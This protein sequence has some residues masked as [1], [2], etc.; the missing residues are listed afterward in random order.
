VLDNLQYIIVLPNKN[1]GSLGDTISE[2][3]IKKGKTIVPKLIEKIKDTT[4][5]RTIDSDDYDNYTVSDV[6]IILFDWIMYDS[7]ECVFPVEHLLRCEFYRA[8]G[9]WNYRLLYYQSFFSKEKESNYKNRLRFYN[10]IKKWYEKGKNYKCNENPDMPY[11][12]W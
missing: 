3:I 6:A 12:P 11:P 8:S 9:P 2:R 10:R 1:S 5:I 4:K 7:I